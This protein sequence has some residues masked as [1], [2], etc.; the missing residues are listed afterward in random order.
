MFVA[1]TKDGRWADRGVGEVAGF[2]GFLK[3]AT[4]DRSQGFGF[5]YVNLAKILQE[6]DNGTA[7]KEETPVL[8]ANVKTVNFNKDQAASATPTESTQNNSAQFME[9]RAKAIDQI[10][11]NLDRLQSLHHRLHAILD[12][13]NQ[14]TNRDKK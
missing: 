6:R 11:N 8:T 2:G 5:M 13:L 10:K 3:M 4:R 7:H 12:E 9:E 1:L 14:I